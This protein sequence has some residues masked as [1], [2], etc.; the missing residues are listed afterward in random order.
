VGA[1][2]AASTLAEQAGLVDPR[3]VLWGFA[4][5]S[6]VDQTVE[7]PTI[8]TWE[9]VPG[10]ALCGYGWIFPGP[11]GRA[12]MGLG[13]GTLSDRRAG[14]SAVRLFDRFSDH[15]KALGLLSAETSP[16]RQRLGGWLKMGMVGTLPTGDG[17]MLV[18][19]AAGLVNPLQGEGI[20]HAMT[21]ARA[22]AEAILAGPADAAVAYRLAL[23]SAHLRYHRVSATAQAVVLSRPRALSA[24]CRAITLP[25][26]GDRLAEGWAVFWN[27]LFEGAPP[28]RARRS[29]AIAAT[30]GSMVTSKGATAR[31]FD[32]ALG[33][34][35]LASVDSG[36]ESSHRT[37]RPPGDPG[38]QAG[39]G[40][41]RST[42]SVA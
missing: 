42:P 37:F 23:R 1:D 30:L 22:A 39:A 34:G 26:I 24:A 2:G 6:Y 31:W 32:G 16:E 4:V 35:L 12:N 8:V 29:A 20:A 9:P 14:A 17:V 3:R 38:D 5:R 7:L 41:R 11:G 27:E 15:L 18:G 21:S 33:A 25:W 10:R 40:S 19:D 28:G 36:T 13:V